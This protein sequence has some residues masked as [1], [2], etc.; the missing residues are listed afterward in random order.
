MHTVIE[1]DCTGCELCVEAC[2]V[3][4][5]D[6]PEATAATGQ[7]LWPP[8]RPIDAERAARARKLFTARQRRLNRRPTRQRRTSR[9]DKTYDARQDAIAT[10]PAKKATIA[11]AVA[12]AKAKRA[13]RGL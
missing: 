7:P 6:M 11:A 4:C 9:H 3:D 10:A 1:A 5:I 8:Q 2:P 13:Q 12:R